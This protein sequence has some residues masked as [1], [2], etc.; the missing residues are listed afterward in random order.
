MTTYKRCRLC[1]L[2]VFFCLVSLSHAHLLGVSNP[3]SM[4]MAHAYSP[5]ARG[6]ESAFYNPSTLAYPA[7]HSWSIVLFAA[8]AQLFNNSYTLDQYN[9]YN[10]S[11]IT[12]LDKQ[13]IL[14]SIPD[15]TILARGSGEIQIL[16]VAYRSWA[17]STGL[18]TG[19]YQAVAKQVLELAFYGN[20]LDRTFRFIPVQG[21][22]QAFASFA[23]SRAFSLTPPA[24]FIDRLAAG[25]TLKYLYG[26]HYA[27]ITDS[28][29]FS[30]TDRSSMEASGG[31]T[32]IQ[33]KGGNGYSVD[34]GASATLYQNWHLSI[35]LEN[36]NSFINWSQAP[37]V[38]QATFDLYDEYIEDYLAGDTDID[39]VLVHQDST[40][41]IR[42]FSTSLP[43]Q[44][45][46]GAAYTFNAWTVTAEWI[47]GFQQG[48]F[49]SD[50]NYWGAGCHVNPWPFLNLRVG[51]GY[52][53]EGGRLFST[54]IG[55]STGAFEW[56][57]AYQSHNALD[58]GSCKGTA[59]A[60]LFALKF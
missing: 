20:E 56:D 34:V 54:G 27:S 11:V 48:A 1:F 39:S 60:L 24:W 36:A 10:G 49:V 46:L 21:E 25:V 30:R 58:F 15:L 16:S 28:Y 40:F 6:A 50:K 53:Q 23:L 12:Q 35:H 2:A 51:A 29:A 59:L 38:Y 47:K 42:E 26:I 13:N 45:H 57:V 31:V 19:A 18:S 44:L 33:A 52:G 32:A 3:R 5:L 7:S 43:V 9:Q 22:G 4:A 55:F 17:L 8:G 41:A 37:K 14:S